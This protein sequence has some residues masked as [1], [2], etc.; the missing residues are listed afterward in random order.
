MAMTTEQVLKVSTLEAVKNVT[1]LKNNISELKRVI[2]GW[3]ETTE[4]DGKKVVKTFEG[5]TI[6]SKEYQ[7]AIQQLNEN[8]AA[9]RNAMHGTA[10][11]L[12]EVREAAKGAS[13]EEIELDAT[14]GKLVTDNDAAL[15]SYN[16]LVKT[17]A[18]LKEEWRATTDTTER[19]ALGE[20]INAVNNR[21]KELDASVG[22]YGRNVGSYQNIVDHLGD[23]LKNLG[24]F[25]PGVSKGLGGITTGLKAM[26]A[27]PAIA[28]L[29]ILARILEEVIKALKSSEEGVESVTAAFGAFSGIGDT[30]TA[31]LQKVAEGVGWLARQFV[32]LLDKLNLV[33]DK[34]REKQE[35]AKEEIRIAREQRDATMKNAEAERDIA[36][37]RAK[38]ADKE[39]YTTKERIAFLE[40]ASTKEQEIAARSKKAAKDE[41]ELIKRRNALTKS[42]AEN[43]KA[44]ADAYARM[45]QADT[46]YQNAVRRN[47][48]EITAARKEAAR[49]AKERLKERTDAEKARLD[50]EKEML[51]LELSLLAEGTQERLNKQK[52]LSAKEYEI[53][54]NNAKA[55]IKNQDELNKQL[56]LLEKIHNAE[57]EK[58]DR[59]FEQSQ[60]EQALLAGQNELD[61]LE[62]NSAAYLQKAIEL[63]QV[64]LDTLAQMDGE[65][66]AEYQARVIAAQEALKQA[67]LDYQE[68][69]REQEATEQENRLTLV[70]ENQF[71]QMENEV[72]LREWQL[73]KV[74]E[75]G[76][77]EGETEAEFRAR[78]LAAEKAFYDAKKKQRDAW[79]ST[80][81]SA[82]GAVSG[83]LGSIADMYES[84]T[85]MTEAEAKKAKNLRIASA[86]IDM[87][88]GAVTAYAGAQSLGVPMGPIVGAINAAAV[89]AA[90]IANIAKIRA[91]DV[92]KDSSGGSATATIPAAVSAPSVVPDFQETRTITSASEEDRLNQMASEHRVYILSSDLEAD[93]EQTRA[94]V[95]ETTF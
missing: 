84:N 55:K 63:K 25:A 13:K 66:D 58:M 42:S 18:N 64:Q 86:T 19:A 75:Y 11:S 5:L 12:D 56:E 21:L 62:K 3:T 67:R 15:Q 45:V 28:I 51:N 35:I 83:I 40:E 78:E 79:L 27:T 31:I 2:N 7:Q 74:R 95:A 41:Y 9:L 17:L 39:K 72:A 90:G 14:T 82:A 8:Q 23:S 65:S 91:T 92:N 20:K 70:E 4:E 44:E 37:L 47:T 53:S 36:E 81:T 10:A 89:V 80:M 68:W 76:Q 48:R 52:E 59:D 60:V 54:V 77:L 34:M 43:L 46:N 50:A 26:S 29:G 71:Q 93:R 32:N 73:E 30:I 33:N 69:E 38:A 57:L 88:Q 94:R 16:G 49:E 6:G 24:T 1:D 61:R 22:V 87:L 85:E